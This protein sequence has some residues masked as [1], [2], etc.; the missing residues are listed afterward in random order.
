MNLNIALE[1][2]LEFALRI[3]KLCHYLNEAKREFVLTKELP[4]SGTNIG[5]PV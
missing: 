4:I 2:S 1:K 5:R 3:V